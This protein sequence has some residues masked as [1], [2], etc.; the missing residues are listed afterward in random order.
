MTHIPDPERL[1]P[2]N[3]G[4]QSNETH[5]VAI[6]VDAEDRVGLLKDISTLLA[7]Q[8]V[9]ILSMATQ[10]HE[11]RTVTFRAVVEVEDLNQLSTMLS[12][13]EQLRQVNSVRREADRPQ[14]VRSTA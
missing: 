14:Q 7:D 3:W 2:V 9:N 13:L 10:T 8:R 11:D 4:N 5:P 12:K 1:V 6:I